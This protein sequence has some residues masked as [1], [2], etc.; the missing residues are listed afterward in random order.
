MRTLLFCSTSLSLLLLFSCSDEKKA[1][2]ET[3]QFSGTKT[4]DG[5]GARF[6]VRFPRKSADLAFAHVLF[7]KQDPASP[8]FCFIHYDPASTE[9]KLYKGPNPLDFTA[10]AKPG[11]PSDSVQ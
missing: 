5:A 11:T 3:P 10:G 1:A 9:L 6:T 8:P 7:G 4:A 2:P